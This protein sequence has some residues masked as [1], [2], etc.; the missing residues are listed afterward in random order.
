[1]AQAPTARFINL[2]N[3]LML[4]RPIP[5]VSVAIPTYRREGVLLDTLSQLLGLDS[6]PAEI[7]VMDQTERH[8]PEVATALA[9]LA[10]SGRIVWRRL[11]EPSIPCAMNAA[12]TQARHDVV[13]FLDDDVIL[14]PFIVEA[15]AREY[16]DPAVTV[17]VGRVLQPWEEALPS[18]MEA[19]RNGRS[20]DPDAFRFNSSDRRWIRRVMA[21]N[22]SLRRGPII[23]LGGFDENFVRVAYRF[24]AEFSERVLRAGHRILFQPDAGL[25]HLKVDCGGT[26]SFG[27]HLTT[28][29]PSHS[30]GEYY[31]RLRSNDGP[32][33]KLKGIFTRLLRGLATRHHLRRPWWIP[34]TLTAELTGLFWAACLAARG[35]RLI[36]ADKGPR[37]W[38]G[39]S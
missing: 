30:V 8:E 25:R 29:G 21:G 13:L 31:Y 10:V 23:A 11:P 3:D 36:G 38:S 28:P 35:P 26:R 12:L 19:F 17:V 37:S 15:H 32:L 16:L 27:H 20:E 39:G 4:P 24:E 9:E 33:V 18:G 7:L 1:V 34:V 5:P 14:T 2:S 6:P 22:L